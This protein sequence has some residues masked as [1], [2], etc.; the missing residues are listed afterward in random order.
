[1]PS[2][3]I[4]CTGWLHCGQQAGH[5]H[6]GLFLAWYAP[7]SRPLHFLATCTRWIGAALAPRARRRRSFQRCAALWADLGGRCLQVGCLPPT[8]A[9]NAVVGFG[10]ILAQVGHAYEVPTRAALPGFGFK[11]VRLMQ[12]ALHAA[13]SS[14]VA[15]F[16]AALNF[17]GAEVRQGLVFEFSTYVTAGTGPSCFRQALLAKTEF[18]KWGF[19]TKC[20]LAGGASASALVGFPDGCGWRHW[21]HKR[22]MPRH[23]ISNQASGYHKLLLV[24]SRNGLTN[25]LA[26]HGFKHATTDNVFTAHMPFFRS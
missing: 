24:K 25:P 8:F 15:V 23:T 4:P 2:F 13:G 26:D 1:M 12:L 9:T 5:S 7:P 6:T 20:T 19:V 11:L 14:Q 21:L 22:S 3:D 17:R 10:V 16:C 18:R